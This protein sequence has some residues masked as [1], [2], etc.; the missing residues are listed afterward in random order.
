MVFVR[1]CRIFFMVLNFLDF[2]GCMFFVYSRL[3]IVK[4]KV[5]IFKGDFIVVGG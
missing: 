1:F 3:V 5:N 2:G 4:L